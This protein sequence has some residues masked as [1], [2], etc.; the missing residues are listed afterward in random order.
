MDPE[1]ITPLAP[2]PV[3]RTV[4]TQTWAELTFLHWAVEPERVAA[5]LPPGVRPDTF[6]GKTYVALVPFRMQGIG[7]LGSPGVPYFGD[8]LETNV[9]LYSVDEKGRRGV[10]FVSLDAERLAPVL[11]ARLGP[12]LPYLWSSMGYERE[13]DR[14][15]YTCRR[16]P[17][18]RRLS[19]SPVVTPWESRFPQHTA[20][21]RIGVE[22]GEEIPADRVGE[23]EH[24][25]TARWGLHQS[26]YYWPN[27]HGS[28]PLRRASLAEF[29][30]EILAAAGFGE[31]AARTPDS[32]LFSSGVH[33]TFGPRVR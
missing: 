8:F 26:R 25:L 23:L 17:Y 30:D 5:Y 28:W 16:R 12:G 14:I 2:R 24:W 32:V 1:P 29:D 27:E 33:A 21:S 15:T 31:L 9:R 10:V 19:T 6:G 11:V 20:T 13:G 3:G 7:L 18:A 22:V 4:F